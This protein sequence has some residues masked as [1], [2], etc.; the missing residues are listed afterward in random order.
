MRTS[1]RGLLQINGYSVLSALRLRP[2][3]M[4]RRPRP[5]ATPNP[6]GGVCLHIYSGDK[7]PWH[8][9]P[10]VA[11]SLAE[12]RPIHSVVQLGGDHPRI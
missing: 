2:R 10:P 7:P 6:Q 9:A 8:T 5:A 1:A 11:A 12:P 4:C 3:M